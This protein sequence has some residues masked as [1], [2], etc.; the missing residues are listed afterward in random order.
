MNR[1]LMRWLRSLVLP[2][3]LFLASCGGSGGSPSTGDVGAVFV[4]GEAGTAVRHDS[5]LIRLTNSADIDEARRIVEDPASRKI[6]VAKIAKGSDGFNRNVL[7]D[8]RPWDWH[9]DEFVGFADQSGELLDGWPGC[10]ESDV[11]GWIGNTGKGDG[12][13][14]VGFWSYTIVEELR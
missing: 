12:F 14:Y 3:A 9:V 2:A 8:G 10:V 4:V 13:G 11:D 7:G 6:V 1:K 5:Y